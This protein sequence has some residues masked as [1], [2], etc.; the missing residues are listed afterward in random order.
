M[1]I[2]VDENIPLMTVQVLREHGHDVLDIRGTPDEGMEDET[3]WQ[4][5]QKEERLFITNDRDLHNTEM[6]NIMVS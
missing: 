4:M 2:L 5:T 6:K 1:K 3:L